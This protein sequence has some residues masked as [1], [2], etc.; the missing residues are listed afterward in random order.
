MV[1]RQLWP[2]QGPPKIHRSRTRDLSRQFRGEKAI[3]WRV[4]EIY[5][6]LLF[7]EADPALTAELPILRE[8]HGQA[9]ETTVDP[10][11]APAPAP[12]PEPKAAPIDPA[13]VAEL[14]RQL[15]EARTRASFATAL[16]VI[17]Q[18]ENTALRGRG[19]SF[20]WFNQPSRSDGTAALASEAGSRSRTGRRTAAE[21]AAGRPASGRAKSARSGTDASQ[22]IDPATTPIRRQDYRSGQRRR[23]GSNR[24]SLADA[25]PPGARTPA[26]PVAAAPPA[27]SPALAAPA[28]NRSAS[29]SQRHAQTSDPVT[30][31]SSLDLLVSHE[32]RR[33]GKN[34]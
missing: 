18:A 11:G 24:S 9:F 10:D 5:V 21:P 2:D 7:A 3:E 16:L 28:R 20:D 30:D 29:S 8:L 19:S 27:P 26:H 23:S 15:A 22:P 6:S 34:S 32:K 1:A 4:V 12:A 17:V 25:F 31:D 33:R 14:E 13:Y